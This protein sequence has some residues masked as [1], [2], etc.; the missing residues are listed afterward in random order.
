MDST[1]IAHALTLA[2]MFPVLVAWA[3]S[4][5]GY[6]FFFWLLLCI[7]TNPVIVAFA[8]A[9]LPNLTLDQRRAREAALLEEQLADAGLGVPA[10][11]A[12]VPPQSLGDASTRRLSVVRGRR[13]SKCSV[14]ERCATTSVAHPETSSL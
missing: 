4:R 1:D 13:R 6:S 9:S 5:R 8:L 11:R 2:L 3:A 12:P 14:K 7:G 10:L